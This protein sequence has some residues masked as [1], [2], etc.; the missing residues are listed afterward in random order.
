[1]DTIRELLD[2]IL[3]ALTPGEPG[4]TIDYSE[5]LEALDT[6][7]AELI[8][9]VGESEDSS[10]AAQL[11]RLRV[12]LGYGEGGNIETSLEDIH[13]MLE[14]IYNKETEFP[15]A[16][17]YNTKLNAII[18]ALNDLAWIRQGLGYT[19]AETQTQKY[20][21]DEIASHLNNIAGMIDI[22]LFNM[23]TEISGR[24]NVL[25]APLVAI[26]NEVLDITGQLQNILGAMGRDQTL[27]DIQAKLQELIDN[28]CPCEGSVN[29]V[30]DIR[31][32]LVTYRTAE[33]T[34]VPLGVIPGLDN[35][36][37]LR[38]N[39]EPLGLEYNEIIPG[40]ADEYSLKPTT[41]GGWAS[42]RV[43]VKSS[44][45]YWQNGWDFQIYQTDIWYECSI[46][47]DEPLAVFLPVGDVGVAT[48]CLKGTVIDPD[49]GENP[50]EWQGWEQGFVFNNTT[51]P[52]DTRWLPGEGGGIDDR[53]PDWNDVPTWPKIHY[54]VW[55]GTPYNTV[56]NAALVRKIDGIDVE[57]ITLYAGSPARVEINA[58]DEWYIR[59][60]VLDGTGANSQIAWGWNPDIEAACLPI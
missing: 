4:E 9:L 49:P 7:L 17:D 14:N 45:N 36:T 15:P 39:E 57:V 37:V 33:Q 46:F 42:W 22:G 34:F 30:P 8:E 23:L 28:Q 41:P 35:Y 21:F 3:A 52:V 10:L 50:P 18:T 32:C 44:G 54:F 51:E 16:L 56:Q 40:L 19:S 24:V 20:W 25:L 48:L 13:L 29:D 53:D 60:A 59:S 31:D 1:M 55:C 58:S 43:L 6:K 5:Q 11:H 47:G 12:A 26:R 2:K 27:L 38:W